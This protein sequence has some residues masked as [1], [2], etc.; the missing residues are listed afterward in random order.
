LL[1]FVRFAQ[2]N[3]VPN[4]A[5]YAELLDGMICNPAPSSLPQEDDRELVERLQTKAAQLEVNPGDFFADEIGSEMLLAAC[6]LLQLSR[7]VDLLR[8]EN[9]RLREKRKLKVKPAPPI[10]FEE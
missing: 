3:N 2:A 5:H 1:P 9:T 10:M 8:E 6:R 4:A 7:D